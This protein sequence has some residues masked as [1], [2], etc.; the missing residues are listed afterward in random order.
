VHVKGTGEAL[1]RHN[2]QDPDSR[3]RRLA[4]ARPNTRRVVVRL[5][6]LRSWNSQFSCRLST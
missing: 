3:D 5:T 6:A 4:R 2:G 1:L